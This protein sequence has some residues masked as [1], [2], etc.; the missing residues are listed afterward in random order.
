MVLDRQRVKGASGPVDDNEKPH[1]NVGQPYFAL[2]VS[3]RVH[4]RDHLVESIEPNYLH[5][6]QTIKVP[7]VAD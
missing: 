3:G 4:V 7:V 2:D 5:K 6:L 1:D